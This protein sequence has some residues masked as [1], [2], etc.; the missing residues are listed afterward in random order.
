MSDIVNITEARTRVGIMG[1]TF[2]PIHIGHLIIAENA[3]EQY[4]LDKVL[5][6]P[7]GDP[8]HK[9]IKQITGAEHRSTMAKLSVFDNNHLEYSDFELKRD[10]YIYTADTLTLLTKENPCTD[11]FFIMGEDSLNDIEQWYEPQ[12]IFRLATVLVAI[13]PLDYND[14]KLTSLDNQINILKEKYDASIFRLD[15]PAID[16]SSSDIRDRIADNHSIKYFVHSEVEK[17]IYDNKLYKR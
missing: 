7:S 10:G 4:N 9:D 3:Y 15:T 12:I 2:D 5:V 1:G 17:Y 8:P 6:M 11:Y 16:I 14:D 13:R